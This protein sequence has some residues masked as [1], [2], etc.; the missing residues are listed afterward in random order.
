MRNLRWVRG[1]ILVI[2]VQIEHSENMIILVQCLNVGQVT[3]SSSIHTY[4]VFCPSSVA[5]YVKVTCFMCVKPASAVLLLHFPPFWK[6]TMKCGNFY[7][8][9]GNKRTC[10]W[11]REHW[12]TDSRRAGSH[13]HMRFVD[14]NNVKGDHKPT[15]VC[16]YCGSQ[17]LVS[18]LLANEPAIAKHEACPLIKAWPQSAW[19]TML[20]SVQ[21]FWSLKMT[22]DQM[23]EIPQIST[24]SR[25]KN[26]WWT[27]K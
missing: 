6:I 1:L 4:S 26:E 19:T 18:W 3:L 11:V 27:S 14:G 25:K 9:S 5:N 17:P 7:N 12:D 15:M 8:F 2:I 16:H 13:P 21:H 10:C 22:F 20:Q 23:C 24:T